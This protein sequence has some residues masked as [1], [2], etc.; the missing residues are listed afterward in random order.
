MDTKKILIVIAIVLGLVVVIAS[1]SLMNTDYSSDIK[2]SQNIP[3]TVIDPLV[4]TENGEN[5]EEG[6][7]KENEVEVEEEVMEEE[8]ESE[9]EEEKVEE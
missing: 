6:G 5:L 9:E 4:D 7:I 2:P 8:E 3:P 1:F